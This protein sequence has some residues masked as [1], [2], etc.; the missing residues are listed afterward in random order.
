[1]RVTRRIII[2]VVFMGIPPAIVVVCSGFAS[3][4]KR[5]AEQELLKVS[6]R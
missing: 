1:M 2:A 3:A 4:Y 6:R 5:I